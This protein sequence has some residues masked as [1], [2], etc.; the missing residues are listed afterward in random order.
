MK[1]KCTGLKNLLN[2]SYVIFFIAYTK[3]RMS[4]LNV[5]FV[6]RNV[7]NTWWYEIDAEK[8]EYKCCWVTFF[9]LRWGITVGKKGI[10]P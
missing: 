7:V 10:D 1:K 3:I 8:I 6:F 9:W 2:F 5:D 4:R